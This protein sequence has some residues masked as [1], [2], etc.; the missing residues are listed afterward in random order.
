MQLAKSIVGH[1]TGRAESQT[2]DPMIS[3][4]LLCPLIHNSPTF[5]TIVSSLNLISKGGKLKRKD[6]KAAISDLQIPQVNAQVICRQV[7][8][9]ITVD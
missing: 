3:G 5:L 6:T 8:L 1:L 2:I 4:Q 7:G 9:T